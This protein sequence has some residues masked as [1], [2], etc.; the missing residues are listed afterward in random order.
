M[1]LTV[2][3]GQPAKFACLGSW[4]SRSDPSALGLIGPV[5]FQS[6]VVV[7]VQPTRCCAKIAKSVER[8]GLLYWRSLYSC[9][10]DVRE[11]FTS[12]TL[13]VGHPVEALSDVRSTDARSA[14]ISRCAG[15][16]RSF[17]VSLYKVEP[18]KA[19]F[20]RNLFAKHDWRVAL[21]NETIE[22]GPEMPL[23][24]ESSAFSGGAERLAGATAGPNGSVVGPSCKS[25]GV[26]PDADAGKEVTLRETCEV[27]RIHELNRPFI[28]FSVC[29]MTRRNQVAEPLG[30]IRINF[31]VVDHR[32][33]YCSGLDCPSFRAVNKLTSGGDTAQ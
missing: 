20:A 2:G 4:S 32:L 11:W 25:Q 22:L 30:R 31:V 17:Q 29:D 28:D 24:G 3:V 19:V 23:V 9:G 1:S 14:Q 21:L 16:A 33:L 12:F 15:V 10:V 6:L 26:G 5:S 8:P 27:R 7:V 18:L 13:G